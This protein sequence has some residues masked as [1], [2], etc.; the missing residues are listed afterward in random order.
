MYGNADQEEMDIYI[1]G[2]KTNMLGRR[3]V[4]LNDLIEHIRETRPDADLDIRVDGQQVSP[5]QW[6]DVSLDARS[7]IQIEFE[8]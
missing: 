3:V 1:N 2:T 6:A 8:E 7:K 5:S 4:S